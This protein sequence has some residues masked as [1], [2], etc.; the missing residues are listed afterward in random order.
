MVPASG[1][2]TQ[3]QARTTWCAPDTSGW[4]AVSLHK[5]AGH[6]QM[7]WEPDGDFGPAQTCLVKLLLANS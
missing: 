4:L 6:M 7:F 1:V 2:Q 5:P 3:M